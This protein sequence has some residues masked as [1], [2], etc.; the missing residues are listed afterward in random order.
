MKGI[1]KWLRIAGIALI[2]LGLLLQIPILI[3]NTDFRIKQPEIPRIILSTAIPDNDPSIWV[4]SEDTYPD[5]NSS[6]TDTFEWDSSDDNSWDNS[7]DTWSDDNSWDWGEDS[8][9]DDSGS[10]D[11]TYDY[12]GSSD[13]WGGS[14]DD[15]NDSGSWDSDW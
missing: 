15:W 4:D 1:G 3:R 7:D 13:D 6:Q 11:D 14:S 12:G 10:W 5:S 9:W 8:S 2:L